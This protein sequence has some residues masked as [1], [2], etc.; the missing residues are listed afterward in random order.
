MQVLTIQLGKGLDSPISITIWTLPKIPENQS[1]TQ[2]IL[3]KTHRMGGYK[4]SK[5]AYFHNHNPP[6][7][8]DTI[9]TDFTGLKCSNAV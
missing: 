6:T 4:L 9:K 1:E 2:I 7:C 3:E 5:L 8:E